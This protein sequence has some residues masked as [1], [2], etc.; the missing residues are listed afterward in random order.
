MTPAF[1]TSPSAF[2]SV[3]TPVLFLQLPLMLNQLPVAPASKSQ[4]PILKQ[5]A[6]CICSILSCQRLPPFWQFFSSLGFR[7]TYFSWF[8][9]SL[10][11]QLFFFLFVSEILVSHIPCSM[12]FFSLSQNVLPRYPP[13]S[14]TFSYDQHSD[15]SQIVFPLQ[16]K[17][18][19]FCFL[20][21]VSAHRSHCVLVVII[22]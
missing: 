16:F 17:H 21:V 19:C 13:P 4:W 14:N 3:H 1:S 15:E 6:W 12:H 11:R 10:S 8:F 20:V 7:D 5:I 9:S 22:Q 18:L 2:P